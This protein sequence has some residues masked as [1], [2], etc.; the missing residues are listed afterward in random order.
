M[1]SPLRQGTN[2]IWGQDARTFVSYSVKA[3]TDRKLDGLIVCNQNKTAIPFYWLWHGC[4]EHLV[5]APR[6]RVLDDAKSQQF[7]NLLTDLRVFTGD[8]IL[9]GVRFKGT[10]HFG[11]SISIVKG[12]RLAG[13]T[14]SELLNMSENSDHNTLICLFNS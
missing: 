6:L 5:V 14:G 1:A 10:S 2:I 11:R 3:R 7:F 9:G 8:C 13:T 12:F 4:K